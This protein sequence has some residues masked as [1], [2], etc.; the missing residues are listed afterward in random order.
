MSKRF[1]ALVSLYSGITVA[2][3]GNAATLFQDNFESVSLGTWSITSVNTGRAVVTTNYSPASGLWHLVLDDAVNDALYSVAEATFSLDLSNKRNVAL[4]FKAKSLGNEPHPP[5]ENFIQGT[6]SFDGVSVSVD[7]GNNWRPIQSLANVGTA[8][9]SFS[10][11]LDNI[12]MLLGGFGSGFRVRF[13]AYDNAPAPLDGIAI[14]DVL[15]TGDDDQR[16]LLE[17]PS[18]LREG[19]GD[20]L[21]YLLL[22]IPP[23]TNLAVSLSAS[24]T[25]NVS[26]PPTVM[27][28]SISRVR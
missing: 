24:P 28:C 9:E 23:A 20:A 8:W 15:L 7:G 12:A 17:L 6:R 2:V 13:S 19:D 18:Q 5:P 4:A 10:I 1:F 3:Q 11:N 22:S 26:L 25:G 16:V 27:P 14:D 21:G